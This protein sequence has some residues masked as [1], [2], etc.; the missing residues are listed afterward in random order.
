MLNLFTAKL[1]YLGHNLDSTAAKNET[2][3]PHKN[4]KQWRSIWP[5]FRRRS[6]FTYHSGKNGINNQNPKQ[7]SFLLFW[8]FVCF[9]LFGFHTFVRSFD[10]ALCIQQRSTSM[11]DEQHQIRS[12]DSIWIQQ[13]PTDRPADNTTTYQHQPAARQSFGWLAVKENALPFNGN[14]KWINC[15]YY[16]NLAKQQNAI[17]PK[18]LLG[19]RQSTFFQLINKKR[20]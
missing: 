17:H 9:V 8:K 20:K 1:K 3:K 19:E 12:I 4:T 6:V 15:H 2:K 5:G 16:A 10:S 18:M 11:D 13:R 14:C 7:I